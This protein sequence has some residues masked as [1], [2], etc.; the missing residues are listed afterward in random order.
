MIDVRDGACDEFGEGFS[1]AFGMD[2]ASSEVG[3]RQTAKDASHSS[4]IRGE[5]VHRFFDGHGM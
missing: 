2:S 3:F 4:S 5:E 1:T